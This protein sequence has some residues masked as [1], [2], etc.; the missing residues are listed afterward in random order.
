MAGGLFAETYAGWLFLHPHWLDARLRRGGLGRSVIAL[1]EAAAMQH[2][3]HS[4]YVD[5][6]SFQ[7][8]GFYRK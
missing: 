2:G 4:A 3:C 5:T 8:P 7:A 1:A 6:F